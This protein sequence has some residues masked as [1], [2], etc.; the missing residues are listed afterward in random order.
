MYDD[1]FF[2]SNSFAIISFLPC[3]EREG[4][5]DSVSLTTNFV[6]TVDVAGL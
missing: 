6:D 4:E 3:I 2:S 1:L 5:I